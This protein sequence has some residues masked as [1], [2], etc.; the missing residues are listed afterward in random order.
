MA[1]HQ[2]LADLY[3]SLST[4]ALTREWLKYSRLSGVI[5]CQPRRAKMHWPASSHQCPPKCPLAAAYGWRMAKIVIVPSCQ[6]SL[7]RIGDA[8]AACDMRSSE[9]IGALSP[10]DQYH[11]GCSLLCRGPR[12]SLALQDGPIASEQGR[13]HYF[14]LRSGRQKLR[15]GRRSDVP[16]RASLALLP[17][18][19]RV[20]VYQTGEILQTATQDRSQGCHS[21]E[22]LLR[23]QQPSNLQ[24]SHARRFS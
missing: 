14:L 21:R 1:G 2:P 3:C 15:T 9:L 19:G 13:L 12:P 8:I 5:A 11:C 20:A 23:E 17:D 22:R 4:G 6:K 24:E 18:L 7:R 10:E 16:R